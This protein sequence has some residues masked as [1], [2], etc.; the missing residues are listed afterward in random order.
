MDLN[1]TEDNGGG[2]GDIL[3]LL[4]LLIRRISRNLNQR[5]TKF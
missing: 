1:D 3:Q 5:I 2:A 4:V